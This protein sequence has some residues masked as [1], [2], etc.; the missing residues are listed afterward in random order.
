V[1]GSRHFGW[2][3]SDTEE[4]HH[5]G[6]KL[7]KHV[8][9]ICPDLIPDSFFSFP[10]TEDL[11][12]QNQIYLLPWWWAVSV[13]TVYCPTSSSHAVKNNESLRHNPLWADTDLTGHSLTTMAGYKCNSRFKPIYV[14]AAARI[15]WLSTMTHVLAVSA[16]SVM[17][18]VDLLLDGLKS[19]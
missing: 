18:L 1:Q 13:S 9:G 16:V 3:V 14:F 2:S 4:N 17:N 5:A 15:W 6:R 19:R 8:N 7:D 10:H 12:P 11:T